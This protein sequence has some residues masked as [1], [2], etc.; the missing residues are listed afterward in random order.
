MVN[1]NVYYIFVPVH[2]IILLFIMFKNFIF[3]ILWYSTYTHESI[4]VVLVKRLKR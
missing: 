3:T 4:C 2:L 1:K